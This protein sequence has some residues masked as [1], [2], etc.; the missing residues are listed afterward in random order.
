MN[1][2]L[3]PMSAKP[4]HTGHHKLI[5]L[6]AEQND[7]VIVYV[8]FSG[9]GVRK[10]KDPSD[11]RTLKQGARKI[12]MPKKGEVPIFGSDMKYIWENVLLDD[13]NLPEHV[14]FIFPDDTDPVSPIGRVHITC[15]ALKKSFDT[16]TRVFFVPEVG[17]RS[18]SDTTMISIYSDDQDISDNYPDNIMTKY[19]GDLFG[20]NIHLVS[21]LRTETIDISGTKMRKLISSSNARKFKALLPNLSEKSKNII[22][23]ILFES[24]RT[25]KPFMSRLRERRLYEN[26]SVFPITSG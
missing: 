14:R 23:D 11:R 18:L 26:V 25:G 9:R 19:Y 2:A 3:I 17:L 20:E 1:V 4:Y 13:L 7:L 6:A 24:A 15:E 21:V 8:S 16:G 22:I 12:E 10:I 5:E